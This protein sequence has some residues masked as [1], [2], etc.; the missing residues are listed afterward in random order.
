M[1]MMITTS[2]TII[3]PRNVVAIC[4]NDFNNNDNKVNNVTE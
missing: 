3:L 2:V 4:I 1:M